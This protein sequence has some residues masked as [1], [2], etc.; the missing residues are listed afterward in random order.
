MLVITKSTC[1]YVSI[2]DRRALALRTP[3]LPLALRSF[4]RYCHQALDILSREGVDPHEV[5]VDKLGEAE[6]KSLQAE[7]RSTYNHSTYPAI[8]INGEFVGGCDDLVALDQRG[9]LLPLL[10]R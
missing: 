3:R 5:A 9:G 7:L 2:P 6:R 4:V 1:P 8:F 10:G